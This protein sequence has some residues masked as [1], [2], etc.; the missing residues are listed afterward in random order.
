MI[1]NQFSYKAYIKILHKYKDK[2]CDSANVE[3]MKSYVLLRFK[4][5]LFSSK[6]YEK[7]LN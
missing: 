6:D 5:G 2:F 7:C 3:S 4:D 1:D